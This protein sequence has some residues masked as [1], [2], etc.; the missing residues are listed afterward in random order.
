MKNYYVGIKIDNS[1]SK[2]SI[3][4]TPNVQIQEDVKKASYSK[5]GCS[6]SGHF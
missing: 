5:I 3:A 4:I 2:T 6:Y 1:I